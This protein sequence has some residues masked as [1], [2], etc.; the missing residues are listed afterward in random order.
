VIVLPKERAQDVKLLVE[1]HKALA[2]TKA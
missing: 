2:G 1:R